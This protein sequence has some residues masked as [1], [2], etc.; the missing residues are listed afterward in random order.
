M[1]TEEN[2]YEEYKKYL[3]SSLGITS[4]AAPKNP[5]N[6]YMRFYLERSSEE[7][8]NGNNDWNALAKTL[9]IE[10]KNLSANKKEYYEKIH[11][12]RMRE[13]NALM[14]EYLKLSGKQKV[15]TPYARFVK[16]RYAQYSK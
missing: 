13:R 9:A 6:P 2:S 1:K 14:E 12:I 8:S 11:T 4:L 7:R 15:L 16:K 3:E 10:W 5:M